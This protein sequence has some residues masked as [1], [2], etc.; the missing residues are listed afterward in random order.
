[1]KHSPVG[2]N[3]VPNPA[4]AR[5]SSLVGTHMYRSSPGPGYGASPVG[6]AVTSHL[7]NVTNKPRKGD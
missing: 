2:V 7:R 3:H 1:M 6:A 5:R 4:T